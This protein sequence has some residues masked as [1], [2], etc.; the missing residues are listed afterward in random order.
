MSSTGSFKR[1]L[2]GGVTGGI[3]SA[4]AARLL[5]AGHAVAGFARKE[6]ESAPPGVD[7]IS[8]DARRSEA[9]ENAFDEAE[10][11]LGAID[12]YVHAVGSVFLKPAHLL[13]DAEWDEVITTNLHSAFYAGRA[14]VR[15]M[16]S[17]R[18]GQVLFLSSVASR[19]GLSNHEAIA[20]AKGGINGLVQ[21]LA[22][23]YAPFGLRINAV[24]LGLVETGA[25]SSLL[26]SEKAREISTRMH[27]LGSIG[28]ASDVASLLAWLLSP[29][30]AWMTGQILTFDGG[31]SSVLP[32]PRA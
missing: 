6:P 1:I 26:G 24:A 28:R 11:A 17:A 2:I 4:L 5:E 18:A 21:S 15:R 25:T 13:T 7:F 31:M 3:G 22:A 19:I 16:R 10:E 29:E 27:P 20:A 8:A 14:A 32:K 12:A 30:A 9:V 23:S